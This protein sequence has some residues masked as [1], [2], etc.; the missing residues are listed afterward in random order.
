MIRTALRSARREDVQALPS[1]LAAPPGSSGMR[2]VPGC[3]FRV[4]PNISA[5]DAQSSGPATPNRRGNA[6]GY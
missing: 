5:P 4:A 6:K 2:G 1:E 3:P